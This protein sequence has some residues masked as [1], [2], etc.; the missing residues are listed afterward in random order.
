LLQELLL[1][2]LSLLIDDVSLI[3]ATVLLFISLFTSTDNSSRLS[4]AVWVVGGFM[5]DR[6]E[7]I[8]SQTVS[9]FGMDYRGLW[10]RSWASMDLLCLY[11]I[12]FIHRSFHLNLQPL[13]KFI[14]L[15]FLMLGTL[16][17]LRYLDRDLGF[18]LLAEVYRVGILAISLSVCPLTVLWLGQN[19]V[20]TYKEAKL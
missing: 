6:L 16:Q 5:M 12:W 18:D 14:V 1:N 7:P 10:Y 19:Y 4:L 15:C 3:I 17:F 11:A 20:R 13:A 9:N 2:E 8:L